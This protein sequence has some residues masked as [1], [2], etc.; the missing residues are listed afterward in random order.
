MSQYSGNQLSTQTTIKPIAL[1][2]LKAKNREIRVDS[3]IHGKNIHR[4]KEGTI[5][6]P[7][8]N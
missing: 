7:E 5:N 2:L 3:D 6:L 8:Q 1:Q 4:T